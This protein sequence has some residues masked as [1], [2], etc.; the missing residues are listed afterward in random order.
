MAFEFLALRA[1]FQAVV[2][3][4]GSVEVV[5]KFDNSIV[6]LADGSVMVAKPGTISRDVINWFNDKSAG[7]TQFDIGSQ[8]FV[9]KSDVPAPE[10][11]VRLARFATE[12]NANLDVNAE[13]MVCGSTAS[14][15]DRQL[16]AGRAQRLENELE[17]MEVDSSRISIGRCGAKAAEAAPSASDQDGQTISI[18]LARGD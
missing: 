18:I 12:L 16:A 13:I 11:E 2:P 8:P 4:T 1:C 14:A 9:A 3:R 10:T 5:P 6:A 7:P 15:S 17:G